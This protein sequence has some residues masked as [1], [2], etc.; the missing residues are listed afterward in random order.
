VVA[1]FV[2]IVGLSQQRQLARTQ[3]T[4]PAIAAAVLGILF[5]LANSGAQLTVPGALYDNP[6]DRY[7]IF[8]TGVAGVHIFWGLVLIVLFLVPPLLAGIALPGRGARICLLCGWLLIT[9]IWQLGDTPIEGLVAAPGLYLTWI[10]WIATLLA[11]AALAI[12]PQPEAVEVR[13]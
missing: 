11:T 7:G 1:A 10:A 9:F 13:S 5:A 3:S 8:G 12:R 4:G 2:G 6:N